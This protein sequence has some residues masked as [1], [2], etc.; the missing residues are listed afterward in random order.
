MGGYFSA[1]LLYR[2]SN[3]KTIITVP[4]KKSVPSN[5]IRY[6]LTGLWSICLGCISN[7]ELR[8]RLISSVHYVSSQHKW[9]H[10]VYLFVSSRLKV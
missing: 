7:C 9:I 4:E 8:A 1:V 3:I 5:C 10:G 6:C 2:K